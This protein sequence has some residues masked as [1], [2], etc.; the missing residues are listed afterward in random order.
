MAFAWA[1]AAEL[2]TLGGRM[3]ENAKAVLFMVFLSVSVLPRC[4]SHA[5]MRSSDLVVKDRN[6]VSTIAAAAV[7]AVRENL[8]WTADREIVFVLPSHSDPS[9]RTCSVDHP[10]WSEGDIGRSRRSV[11][12]LPK[13]PPSDHLKIPPLEPTSK[14]GI[15]C[16]TRTDP[17]S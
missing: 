6:E 14:R 12:D 10:W 5:A 13:I 7:A 16:R 4:A 11:S 2:G 17:T 3:Q 8:K 1:E 15:S 9:T